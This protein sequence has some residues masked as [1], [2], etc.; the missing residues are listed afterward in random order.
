MFVSTTI[1]TVRDSD[2]STIPNIPVGKIAKKQSEVRF[3]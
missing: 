3:C 2:E 1:E